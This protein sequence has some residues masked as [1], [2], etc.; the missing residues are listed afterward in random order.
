MKLEMLATNCDKISLNW[1]T[2]I[3]KTKWNKLKL[4]K[5][6]YKNKKANNNITKTQIKANSKYLYIHYNSI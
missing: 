5:N 2:K 1:S 4:N 6:L 3:I